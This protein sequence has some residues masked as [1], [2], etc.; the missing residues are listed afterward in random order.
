M[1]K[2]E[3][4][5]KKTRKLKGGE[6]R[7]KAGSGPPFCPRRNW[8]GKREEKSFKRREPSLTCLFDTSHQ[9]K[10]GERGRGKKLRR[11]RGG[12]VVSSKYCKGKRG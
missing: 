9:G 4:R 8:G 11:K 3:K 6:K 1:A 5:K 2:S 12:G 7:E 10:R